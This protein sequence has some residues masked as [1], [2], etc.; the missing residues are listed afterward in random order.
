ML[1]SIIRAFPVSCCASQAAI[2]D[3]HI[4]THTYILSP[5]HEYLSVLL[6]TPS[7]TSL[8]CS[9][10][11]QSCVKALHH[12]CPLPYMRSGVSRDSPSLVPMC[13]ALQLGRLISIAL[14]DVQVEL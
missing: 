7:I 6:A 5:G 4:L 11:S 13:E 9:L 10:L 14:A 3:P 8:F 2:A 1:P 12:A